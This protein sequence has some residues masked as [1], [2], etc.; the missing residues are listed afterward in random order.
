MKVTGFTLKVKRVTPKQYESD[1]V[2]AVALLDD[3]ESVSEAIDKLKNEVE[4]GLSGRTTSTA[5]SSATVA[6]VELH[7]EEKAVTKEETTVAA[8]DLKVGDAVAVVKEEKTKTKVTKAKPVAS[9]EAKPLKL[10]GKTV[11]YDPNNDIHKQS[12]GSALD[13]AFKEWRKPAMLK[14]ARTITAEL[15]G[16]SF[17]DAEGEVLPEFIESFSTKYAELGGK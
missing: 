12:L 2:E 7:K 17:L 6:T 3:G 11:A 4:R 14:I 8:E 1:E 15:A 13:K 16:A 5:V 10:K 9:A